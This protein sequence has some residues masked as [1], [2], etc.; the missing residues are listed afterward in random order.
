MAKEI[1][2]T[3]AGKTFKA[4][5]WKALALGLAAAPEVAVP[6]VQAGIIQSSSQDDKVPAFALRADGPGELQA[7]AA[8][9]HSLLLSN[10]PIPRVLEAS[11]AMRQFKLYEE[12]HR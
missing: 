7:L 8:A 4:E 2:V 10:G 3:V 6:L 11:H 9:A 12:A 1:E 5:S